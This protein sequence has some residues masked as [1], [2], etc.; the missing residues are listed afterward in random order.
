MA[1]RVDDFLDNWLGEKKNSYGRNGLME[2]FK[3]DFGIHT[4]V[5]NVQ[6]PCESLQKCDSIGNPD[7]P[8]AIPIFLVYEAMANLA[9]YFNMLYS[10]VL[11]DHA[12]AADSIGTI[13]DNFFPDPKPPPTDPKANVN[14]LQIGSLVAGIASFGLMAIPGIGLGAVSLVFL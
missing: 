10:N 1:Y 13:V 11:T 7:S 9:N 8:D 5:C 3:S 4:D 14:P 6:K 2:E 12:F